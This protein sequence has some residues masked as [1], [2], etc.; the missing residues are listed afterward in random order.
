MGLSLNFTDE[1]HMAQKG[2]AIYLR[3]PSKIMK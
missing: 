3:S 1:A 2:E